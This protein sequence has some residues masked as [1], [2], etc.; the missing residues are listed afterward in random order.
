MGTF[1]VSCRISCQ[2]VEETEAL[3]HY[4]SHLQLGLLAHDLM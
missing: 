2:R 1:L 3:T 4:F